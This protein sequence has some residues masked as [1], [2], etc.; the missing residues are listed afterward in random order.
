[1]PNKKAFRK[2]PGRRRE[3]AGS[4]FR[5]VLTEGGK[6]QDRLFEKSRREG[7]KA[8]SGVSKSLEEK[9]GQPGSEGGQQKG[10]HHGRP[11]PNCNW[12]T[13]KAGNTAYSGRNSNLG[14]ILAS[15]TRVESEN[16]S[17]E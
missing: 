1:L 9:G 6:A 12:A 3:R 13:V 4:A 11:D 7:R 15:T 2:A 14:C 5:K 8:K 16:Y 10:G 17:L